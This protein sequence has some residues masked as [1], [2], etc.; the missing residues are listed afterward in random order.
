MTEKQLLENRFKEAVKSFWDVRES[1]AASQDDRG[2]SDSGTRSEVTGGRHFDD[3]TALVK[4]VFANAGLAVSPESTTLPGF[5]RASKSWDLNVVHQGNLVAVIELKSLIGSFG[6]NQNNRIEEM[7]GQSLDL[8]RA[9]RESLLGKI[10]PWFGYLMLVEDHPASNRPVGVS[11]HSAF[12]PDEVFKNASYV[13]RFQIA[14]D[15][16]RREGDINAVCLASSKREGRTVH[17]PDPTMSFSSFAAAIQGRVTEYLGM[18][19]NPD[20]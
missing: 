20:T 15:R 16:L 7:V 18:T 2:V 4:D 1:Q 14:F 12:P 13:E 17:Y 19:G 5:Y 9:T 3:V 8:W 6:N 10:R 11:T